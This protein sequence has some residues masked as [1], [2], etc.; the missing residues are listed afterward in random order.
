MRETSLLATKRLSSCSSRSTRSKAACAAWR[1]V[2]RVGVDAVDLEHRGHRR[3]REAVHAGH[4]GRSRPAPRRRAAGAPAASD[5]PAS[6]RR[7]SSHSVFARVA[8]QLDPG[9]QLDGPLE[10]AHVQLPLAGRRQIVELPHQRRLH[11]RSHED[12]RGVRGRR[13]EPRSTSATRGEPAQV[14]G[15]RPEVLAADDLD[16]H[17]RPVRVGAGQVLQAPDDLEHVGPGVGVDVRVPRIGREAEAPGPGLPAEVRRGGDQQH[18][19]PAAFVATPRKARTQRRRRRRPRAGSSRAGTRAGT[20]GSCR[21]SRS[22]RRASAACRSRG[23]AGPADPRRG[24]P[25]ALQP[26][27]PPTSASTRMSPSVQKG[28]PLGGEV[29]QQAQVVVPGVEVPR[30][31]AGPLQVDPVGPHRVHDAPGVAQERG[32]EQ[33]TT[34]AT[35]ASERQEPRRG[36]ARRCETSGRRCPRQRS[37]EPA[38][39]A[40]ASSMEP[41]ARGAVS[42]V[43]SI[44]PAHAPARRAGTAPGLRR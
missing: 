40:S 16:R 35:A 26:A 12:D 44:S 8:A 27:A 38:S 3:V 10:D 28:V 37:D 24:L 18:A 7:N 5:G 19:R 4:R 30:G 2:A 13:R 20:R 33:A 11:V 9:P 36:R 23:S 32:E 25:R 29:D 34:R 31:G 15:Q 14:P 17:G 21:G 6:S 39:S 43:A 1:G 42:L 22:R 41:S